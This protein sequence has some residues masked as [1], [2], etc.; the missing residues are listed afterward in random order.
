D[1]KLYTKILARRLEGVLPCRVQSDQSGFIKG[2]QTHDN[3]R[4]VIHRIEKVAKKQVPAMPLALDAEK[5][6][7][8]VEWSFLVATLRH[9]RV[10][11][12]FIA[13]VMSNYS[14]PRSRICVN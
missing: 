14:S 2:R 8:R 3:L 1:A 12:Q 11:E 4:R 10:G 9:F 7:D 13:M 5:A 6:F